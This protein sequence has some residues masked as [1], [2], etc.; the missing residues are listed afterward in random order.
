MIGGGCGKGCCM[1]ASKRKIVIADDE[2]DIINALKDSLA[3]GFDVYSALNGQEAVKIINRVLPDLIIMDVLMPVMDGIEACVRVKG[4]PK[5]KDIPV[6][7]LTA[8]NQVEDTQRCFKAG[9]DSHMLKPF[10]PS[11]LQAKVEDMLLKAQI[12]K[13]L[14][15]V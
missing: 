10:S 11:K 3:A 12:K 1:E 14:K 8:V 13:G 4:D 9:G 15:V 5:T 2:S 6:L 7:F